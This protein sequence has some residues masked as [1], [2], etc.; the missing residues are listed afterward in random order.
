MGD[1]DEGDDED[2]DEDDDD[3]DAEVDLEDEE[4][5]FARKQ[6]ELHSIARSQ[7]VAINVHG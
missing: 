6:Q 3:E 5:D 4:D 7:D 2:D 1:D